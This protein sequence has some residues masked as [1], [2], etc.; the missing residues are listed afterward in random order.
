MHYSPVEAPRGVFEPEMPCGAGARWEQTDA[1]RTM[2][3]ILTPLQTRS[4]RGGDVLVTTS[5]REERAAARNKYNQDS[6]RL[7]RTNVRAQPP[8]ATGGQEELSGAPPSGRSSGEELHPQG[9]AQEKTSLVP[10]V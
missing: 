5:T 4:E 2:K 8:R 7:M 9:E 10:A 6:R 3:R 1:Q